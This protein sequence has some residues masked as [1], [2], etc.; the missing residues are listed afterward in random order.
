[1]LF[2]IR[3]QLKSLKSKMNISV[4]LLPE[5]KHVYDAFIQRLKEIENID[6]S[7]TAKLPSTKKD[8]QSSILFEK[9]SILQ[10]II[11]SHL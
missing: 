11:F 3:D 1:M 9:K 5:Q 4:V 10:L 8:N 7:V 2:H 6:L